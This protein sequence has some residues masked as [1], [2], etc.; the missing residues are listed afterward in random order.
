M[1]H[2]EADFCCEFRFTKFKGSEDD[3]IAKRH[4]RIVVV[5]ENITFACIVGR[6]GVDR[7]DQATKVS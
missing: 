3:D 4:L 1:H 2:V 5:E 6:E 7:A